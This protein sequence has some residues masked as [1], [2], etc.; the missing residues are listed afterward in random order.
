MAADEGKSSRRNSSN[1]DTP[2]LSE[3]YATLDDKGCYNGPVSIRLYDDEK[4]IIPKE[5]I[6][7][8]D[9]AGISITFVPEVAEAYGYARAHKMVVDILLWAV[10]SPIESNLIVLSKNFKEEL[11]VCV[12]QGLHGRGYNVLLAEPLEHIPFTESSEWLWDSL[13]RSLSSDGG[14]SSQHVDNKADTV[15]LADSLRKQTL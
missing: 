5:L 1:V 2:Y 8:Y 9:A 13:C 11:T 12:I 3:I 14:G 7:K 6:D 4:N 15:A 10:D